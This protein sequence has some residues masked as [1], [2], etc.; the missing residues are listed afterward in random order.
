MYFPKYIYDIIE[1][2]ENRFEFEK[3]TNNE[4]Q[5][6]TWSFEIDFERIL[7]EYKI[8]ILLGSKEYIKCHKLLN[9][10]EGCL[11]T[12]PEKHGSVATI[13]ENYK[14]ELSEWF[15]IEENKKNKFFRLSSDTMKFMCD[16]GNESKFSLEFFTYNGDYRFSLQHENY[17][18]SSNYAKRI[19]IF[20]L[21]KDE[22]IM[23][24]FFKG[25]KKIYKYFKL[26]NYIG[27]LN[28]RK[29]KKRKNTCLE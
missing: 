21:K 14:K 7:S 26:K 9:L 15:N 3:K 2:Y 16:I 25:R 17:Y 10:T 4:I 27:K 18:Y 12:I 24:E 5:T 22:L 23:E 1:E 20:Y 6:R 13:P 11:A 29:S 19:N 28:S 8:I